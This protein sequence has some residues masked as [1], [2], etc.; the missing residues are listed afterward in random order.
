MTNVA[1]KNK[2]IKTFLDAINYSI[3]LFSKISEVK[4]IKN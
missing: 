1:S 4:S 2:T 3:L